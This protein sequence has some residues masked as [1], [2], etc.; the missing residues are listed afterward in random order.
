MGIERVI[1]MNMNAIRIDRYE[2]TIF[3]PLPKEAW[4]SCGDC[5]CDRCRGG[6]GYWDTIAV[7]AKKKGYR[8][9]WMVHRPELHR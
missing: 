9:T 7:S 3:I 6:E 4:R 1:H 2:D 5:N 8:Y